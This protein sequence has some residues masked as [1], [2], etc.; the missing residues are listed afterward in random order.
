MKSVALLTA[1]SLL[2]PA[3]AE[4]ILGVTVFS[5]HGDRTSKHYKGYNLTNL[6]LQQNYDVGQDY[7]SIYLNSSSPKQILNVSEGKVVNSQ[8][9]ASAPDQA[10]LLNTA[11]AFLQGLYPP[12]ENIDE[13]TATQRLN[14]NERVIKPLG[15]YQYLVVHGENDDSPNTI[16]LKGDEECPAVTTSLRQ[17]KES[18]AFRQR[19]DETRPFYQ[20]FWDQLIGVYDYQQSNLSFANAYDIFDLLNVASIH[21][22][23]HNSTVSAEDLIR[24]RTLADEWEFD[25]AYDAEDSARS[26]GGQTFAGGILA[27]LDAM[28]SSKGRQKFSLLAGSYDTFLAFFG[29]S[30]LTAASGDFYGL[31]DYASTMAFELFTSQ[32]VAAFPS[33]AAD[34]RVRFLFR[35][36][37]T[38]G[39]A[40]TAFPLFGGQDES[41]PYTDFVS[42]MTEIAITSPEQWCGTCQSEALFCQ[43]YSSRTAE[44]QTGGSGSSMSNAA[45]GAIGAAVTLGVV[46]LAALIVFFVRRR[47]NSKVATATHA[48][49]GSV[50][51]QASDV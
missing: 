1:V 46:G 39:E 25:M 40:P 36:G 43:A 15:G 3:Q 20:S 49:K 10:V 9:Y 30:N 35:N 8:I 21:N 23:S 48:E 5:R 26:I 16:W 22:A 51:S 34:L 13:N 33:D 19:I 7:R 4:T 38:Q 6:G 2:A 12:L 45:A 29:L 28:V 47:R 41:L 17:Y 42:K 44:A 18:S 14:S 37:S 50:S 11:T 27:Q 32:D 31:P 24:L